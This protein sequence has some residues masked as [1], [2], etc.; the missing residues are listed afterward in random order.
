M[1]INYENNLI[2]LD[3]VKSILL[4]MIILK[5]EDLRII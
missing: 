1:W 2:N 5:V 3:L 4:Q